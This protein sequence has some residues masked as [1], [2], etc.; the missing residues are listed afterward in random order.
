MNCRGYPVQH[1]ASRTQP[2]CRTPRVTEGP[3]ERFQH[4]GPSPALVEGVTFSQSASHPGR[5]ATRLIINFFFTRE[6][7]ELEPSL[8]SLAFR[9]KVTGGWNVGC[10]GEGGRSLLV[11]DPP[12]RSQKTCL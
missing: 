7:L 2:L 3:S 9:G 8:G 5:P 11:K 6:V 12:A 1:L 4:S 10:G